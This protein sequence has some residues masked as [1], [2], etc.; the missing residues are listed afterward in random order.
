MKSVPGDGVIGGVKLHADIVAAQ[1]VQARAAVGPG[2]RDSAAA[3]T[4]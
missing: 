4:D 1:G 2:V 3:R